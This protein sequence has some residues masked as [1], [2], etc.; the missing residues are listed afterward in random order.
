[1]ALVPS[2][3]AKLVVLENR[4]SHYVHIAEKSGS[5]HF[6]FEIGIFEAVALA[7]K[8]DRPQKEAARPQTHDLAA[9]IISSLGGTVREVRIT[10]MKDGT[11]YGEIVIETEEGDVTIDSRPSDALVLAAGAKCDL[12]VDDSVY[13]AAA[14]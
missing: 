1:M 2:K 14:I 4:P 11:F 8:I 6:S 5:R 12:M 9:N 10:S 13:A 7:R 3:L